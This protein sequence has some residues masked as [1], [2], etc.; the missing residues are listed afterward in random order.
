MQPDFSITAVTAQE[1]AHE[2]EDE[3]E[4]TKRH[5]N[6]VFIGH[7]GKFSFLTACFLST[8]FQ[9]YPDCVKNNFLID[10]C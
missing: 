4:E 10:V 1:D 3:V 6:V 9:C 5:L 2:V 8:L 7:V